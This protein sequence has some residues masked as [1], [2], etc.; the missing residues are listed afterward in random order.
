MKPV[1]ILSFLILSTAAMAQVDKSDW[2][3]NTPDGCTSI[4]AGKDATVD[5]SVITSHTDDSHKT[6]SWMDIQPARNHKPGTMKP[7]YKR[8]SSDKYV[9]PKY[10]HIQIGEIPEVEHT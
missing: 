10:D 5:G 4:T 7:M 9:M 3:Y 6:R 2:V 1:A 8:V